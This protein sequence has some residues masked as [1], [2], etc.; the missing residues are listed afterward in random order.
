M[1]AADATEDHHRR[2]SGPK[3][4]DK[5]LAYKGGDILPQY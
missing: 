3:N 2:T 1:T 5:Y 4:R